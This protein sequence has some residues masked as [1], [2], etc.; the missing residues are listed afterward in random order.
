MK[1]LVK[2]RE[3]YAHDTLLEENDKLFR[4]IWH[5]AGFLHDYVNENDFT[6]LRLGS[7]PIVIQKLRG[8]IRAFHN[9]CSHRHSI[10]Q[11]ESKGNRPLMCPYHGWTYDNNGIPRGIPKKPLFKFTE[12]E[13]DCLKLKEY[14]LETCG[15]L[16]FVCLNEPEVSLNEFLG[17]HFQELALMSSNFDTKID[18]NTMT[19]NANWKI[20]VENTLES[21]HVNMVH[22]NTFKNL[23]AQGLDFEFK[24]LH[25]SWTAPLKLNE[26]D[27]KLKRIHE[28]FKDRNYRIDGYKHICVFPNT[29]ISSTY[30]V[31]FNLSTI[32]PLSASE[33]LFTSFVF[34]A[35]SKPEQDYN[36]L[37]NAYIESL[38]AF[39]RNVFDEDKE[40]CEHVQKGVEAS[41]Y[42]GEL[43]EEERRVCKFQENYKKYM[44]K[45]L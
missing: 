25:S 14:S 30:G 5:F 6:T 21:Y 3:Y 44:Y 33:T 15:Q 36:S 17:D 27:K 24:G 45:E 22:T 26:N 7:Q 42:D 35:R 40:I 8:T 18:V 20:L 31:S 11:T 13:L 41:Q 19:I 29:L 4:K 1:A 43:S 2:P 16:I 37:T 34:L 10:I 12:N 39:N 28:P 9:V 38:I 23:G 32:V